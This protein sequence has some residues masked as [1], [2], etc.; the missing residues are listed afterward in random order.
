[1]KYLSNRDNSVVEMCVTEP[2]EPSYTLTQDNCTKKVKVTFNTSSESTFDFYCV[3][4]TG[5]DSQL[6]VSKSQ[7]SLEVKPE[8]G[9]L[10]HFSVLTIS[11]HTSDNYTAEPAFSAPVNKTI[12]TSQSSYLSPTSLPTKLFVSEKNIEI[13]IKQI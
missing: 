12:H 8:Q 4:Y 5:G 7:P 3:E 2:E 9:V 1:M 10:V 13:R 6:Y 11:N